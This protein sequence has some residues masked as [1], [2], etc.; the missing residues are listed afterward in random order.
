MEPRTAGR[1]APERRS[2]AGCD[3]GLLRLGS[4]DRPP[5]LLIHG[6]SGDL[7]TWQYNLLPLAKDHHVVAIDLPGHGRSAMLDG[8]QHWRHI[9]EWLGSALRELGLERPHLIGHSLGARLALA[10]VERRGAPARSLTLI[11][12]A[13]LGPNDNYPFLRQ[14]ASIETLDDALACSR[15]LFSDAPIDL[16]RFARAMHAKLSPPSARTALER[17]LEANFENGQIIAPELIDWS[18]VDCPVRFIW[19]RNDW[20]A[21]VPSAEFLPPDADIHVFEQIGHLPHI[22]ASDRVNRAIGAFVRSAADQPQVRSVAA[23]E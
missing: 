16:E 14:L 9:V 5:V 6:F 11:A 1:I 4:P 22:A 20:V 8:P 2:I 7:L 12:C 21:A 18:R 10:L 3:I 23:Q 17:F 13:G 19:G 15:H